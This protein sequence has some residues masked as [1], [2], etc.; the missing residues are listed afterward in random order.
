MVSSVLVEVFGQKARTQHGSE[1]KGDQQGDHDRERHG[2]PEAAQPHA[3]DPLEKADRNEDNNQRQGGGAD[4]QAHLGRGGARGF[5]GVHALFF[6]IAINVFQHDNRV[7]NDNAHGQ[8]EPQQGDAIEGI[9]GRGQKCIGRD[10]GH[11]NRDRGN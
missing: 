6:D 11:R 10:D 5:K 9:A 1:G 4:G 8:G 2:K 7:I 3:D